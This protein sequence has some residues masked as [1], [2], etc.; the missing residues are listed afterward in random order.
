MP[1]G[2]VHN[3]IWKKNYWI[4]V[5]FSALCLVVLND[6]VLPVFVLVGYFLGRYLSPDL[7]LIGINSDEG[8]MMRELK[9]IGVF[10]VMYFFLYAYLMRFVGIGRKGHRNFFSHFP[11]ISTAIRLGWVVIPVAILL[12]HFGVHIPTISYTIVLGIFAGLTIADGL[13]YLADRRVIDE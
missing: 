5:L 11:G 6:A 4:A 3:Q 13:H 2:K 1:S 12:T 7:D 9:I 10:L 8:R